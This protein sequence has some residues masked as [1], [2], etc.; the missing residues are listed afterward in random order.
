M[1]ASLNASNA[2]LTHFIQVFATNILHTGPSLPTSQVHRCF[3]LPAP[4][5]NCPGTKSFPVESDGMTTWF[6]ELREIV[7][8]ARIRVCIFIYIYI[9]RCIPN[10]LEYISHFLT[11]NHLATR[12]V[13]MPSHPG[14]FQ[15]AWRLGQ[16]LCTM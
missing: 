13:K 10:F 9:F 11:P 2:R 14:F 8:C 15:F 5:R 12:R 1:V 4:H 3:L 7:T 16:W 6:G